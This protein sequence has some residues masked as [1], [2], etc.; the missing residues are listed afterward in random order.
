MFLA[1]LLEV[2]RRGP[3][4]PIPQSLPRPAGRSDQSFFSVLMQGDNLQGEQLPDRGRDI[5][6]NSAAEDIFPKRHQAGQVCPA[7]GSARVQRLAFV[8][9]CGK[10]VLHANQDLH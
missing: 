10:I 3:D 4:K 5:Q 9:N 8:C 2:F 1:L 6:M 7:L